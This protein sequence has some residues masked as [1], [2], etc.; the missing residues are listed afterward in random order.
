MG[1]RRASMMSQMMKATKRRMERAVRI[2]ERIM[3]SSWGGVAGGVVDVGVGA[4]GP[5]VGGEDAGGVGGEEAVFSGEH[6]FEDGGG[7]AGGEAGFAFGDGA[8]EGGAGEAGGGVL[9]DGVPFLPRISRI[10]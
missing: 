6:V 9:H 3:S 1:A 4:F 10:L 7:F 2:L 8:A 5:A